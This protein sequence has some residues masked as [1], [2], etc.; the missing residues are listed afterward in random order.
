MEFSKKLLTLQFIVSCILIVV[1]ILGAFTGADVTAIAMLAGGSILA[2]GS[3]TAFYFWKA[4]TE[5]RAKYAQKFVQEFAS[6]YGFEA[7]ISLAD[8]VFRDGG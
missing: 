7:A 1:T 5:N 4:R 8:T 2:D 6:V 3:S